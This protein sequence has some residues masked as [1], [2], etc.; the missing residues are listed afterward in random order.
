MKKD[1]TIVF[2]HGNQICYHRKFWWGS[3]NYINSLSDHYDFHIAISNWALIKDYPTAE[4]IEG[5]HEKNVTV[6]NV[7]SA[8][9]R[10]FRLTAPYSDMCLNYTLLNFSSRFH[11]FESCLNEYQI[12]YLSLNKGIEDDTK[13]FNYTITRGMFQVF[14]R[15]LTICYKK[16]K[17]YDCEEDKK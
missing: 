15:Y 16:Y 14:F 10:K 6:F 3:Y 17:N 11:A 7:A 1:K 4:P 9:I 8:A 13:Y 2:I 12:K 5:V